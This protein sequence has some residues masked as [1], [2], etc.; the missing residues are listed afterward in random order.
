LQAAGSGRSSEDAAV[1]VAVED[2][3]K[4]DGAALRDLLAQNPA[5]AAA[6][7]GGDHATPLHV[8]VLV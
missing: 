2:A 3:W 6:R 8:A 4:D 7:R 5:S 1:F